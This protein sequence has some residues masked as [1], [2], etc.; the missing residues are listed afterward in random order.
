M[1]LG[2]YFDKVKGVGVMATADSEGNVNA[3]T[4]SKPVMMDDNTAAFIMSGHLTHHNLTSN[5]KACYFFREKDGY[6]GKRLYLTKIREEEGGDMIE[7]IRKKRYPIFSI[8]YSNESKY[9]VY[10]NVDK[11]LPLVADG[12]LKPGV[13]EE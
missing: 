3:A 4:L 5:P 11:V 1:N 13:R 10:F 6:E 2:E 12:V 9:V 7:S 8:K